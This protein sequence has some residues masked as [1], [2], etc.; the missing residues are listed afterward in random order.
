MTLQTLRPR[1]PFGIMGLGEKMT[2]NNNQPVNKTELV[3]PGKRTKVETVDLPFQTIETINLPRGRRQEDLFSQSQQQLAK[4][5][6]K[7]PDLGQSEEWLASRSFSEGWKNRL[8]WGDNFLVMG[9]LLKEFAGK[10]NLIYIDPPFATGQ[11]F[12]YQV[13][14]GDTE[15]TK[16]PSALEVLAYRD[17]WGKGLESYLQMMYDRLILMKELLA[18]NGSIYVHL[19]WHVVHYLKNILDEI[20]GK[21]NFRNEIV[22][23]YRR[24]NIESKIFNRSHDIIL[25]YSKSP[26]YIFNQMYEPKSPKSS[27]QG[28]AWKSVFD[29]KGRRHSIL[30]GEVT[31]GVPMSDTWEIS[32][33]NP[34]AEE[35]LG[36]ETQKPEGLLERIIKA[37]SDEGDLIADFFCG[38]GTMGTVAEKL[39]RRWI[40]SDIG[41]FAIHTTRKRLLDIPNCK[42][43]VVQNLGKYERHRWM[44]INGDF[45]KY[46]NFILELYKAELIEG[47]ENLH[48]KKENAFVRI[49][50]VDAPVTLAEIQEALEEC[51][52]NK[53]K[54]L[55][56]LGWEWEMGLHDM[57]KDEAER[58]GVKLKTL[59]IP[60]EVMQVD[61]NT[62]QEVK[63]YELAYLDVEVKIG[64]EF[65]DKE[66]NPRRVAVMLKNFILE[67]PEL[68]PQEVRD[69]IK[70][71]SDFVDY[72]AVDWTFDQHKEKTEE[73]DVFHNMN[74]E[75][76]TRKNP[77]LNLSMYYDYPK[78]GQYKIL[79]KVIDIF[80]NDTTKL[81]EVKV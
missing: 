68:I 36:Y 10:I 60:R 7:Q 1:F 62:K 30:T 46:I 32:I 77:K 11:D 22:W 28:K 23:K 26:S 12:S 61:Q 14:I 38:S 13:K 71:W 66:K 72:W 3:W 37:S 16:E 64:G 63:F 42:P 69:K 25:W 79:V 2:E 21:E 80:G 29:E 19:D 35:R 48:G 78:S 56:V 18:D 27:A 9:S 70:S 31:K 67:N 45:D 53:I 65:D 44:K 49:G 52:E 75:Y 74:Q 8:I 50:S 40:M 33:I 41:R 17:T 34:V 73:D 47:Y 59:Q 81:V 57:V 76:R 39:G 54:N 20:F 5:V 58:F 24:W 51:K 6:E 55:D 43:F 4:G 15:W